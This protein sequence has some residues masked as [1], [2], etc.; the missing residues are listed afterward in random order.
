MAIEA[1]TGA[2]N[3]VPGF[4]NAATLEDIRKHGDVLTPGH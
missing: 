3:D 4:C 1:D 2:T